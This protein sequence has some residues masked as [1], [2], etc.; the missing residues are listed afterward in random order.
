MVKANKKWND[1]LIIVKKP[2]AQTNFV[3]RI[4][5]RTLTWSP[6]K[7]KLLGGFKFTIGYRSVSIVYGPGCDQGQKDF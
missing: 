3:P 1:Q 4:S 6:H 2:V 7:H 5:H